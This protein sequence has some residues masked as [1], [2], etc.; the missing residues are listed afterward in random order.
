MTNLLD[1]VNPLQGTNSQYN[2]S[3][4]N[5]LPAIAMPWGM[6]LWSPQNHQ[7]NAWY[8]RYGHPMIDGIRLTHQPSPWMN[9]FAQVALMPQIGPLR[10]QTGA[11]A[12]S[13][14]VDRAT[15]KPNY[16]QI[17]LLRYQTRL[18]MVPTE[19][20][21]L[22]RI[23]Y[24][25]RTT[26]R[27]IIDAAGPASIEIQSVS[28]S[29]NAR[30]V[31]RTSAATDGALPGF[32]MHFV[33]ELDRPI[34]GHGH[35]PVAPRNNEKA[36]RALTYV[37]FDTADRPLIARIATSFIDVEQAQLNLTR[38]LGADSLEQLR[39]RTGET[40]NALLGRVTLGGA[41]DEQ[42]RTF[43]TCLYRALLFPTTGHEPDASG[44]Q[45]H[46]SF[47]DGKIH[48]GVQFTNN[49]FWDTYRT[50]YPLYSILY[51][52][53]LVQI[54][55][56]WLNAYRQSG[57]LPQWPSPGHRGCMI[58]S[59]I[60]PV[61]ADAIVKNVGLSDEEAALAFEAMRKHAFEPS[62]SASVG[63]DGIEAYLRYGFIP[64]GEA[65][66]ATS[67]T[68][69]Y[70][71]DDWCIA[72]VA[73]KIGR[74]EDA[75]EF[76]RRA[77]N[78]RNVFDPSI[79][80]ARP[81]KADGSWISPFDPIDWGGPFVEGSAWQCSWA[82]QHD[83][84]G[85]ANLLGGPEAF[86]A[87]LDQMLAMPPIFGAGHYSGEIHEMT[88]MAIEN[89]GQ[90]GHNNQPSHHSLFLFAAV[91][92]PW[93][94]QYWTRRVCTDLYNAGPD[95][96]C[97]DEDNGEMASWYI[98][99]SLGLC[100]LC[101][102]HPSYV[103]TSPLFPRATIHLPGGRTFTVEAQGNAPTHFY[104]RDLTL[105]GQRHTATWIA[106]ESITAGGALKMRMTADPD[107]RKVAPEDL[108]YSMSAKKGR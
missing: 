81:R 63:R 65:R 17:D 102:G 6:N 4:G 2:L 79:G 62:A 19:R 84:L 10:P 78:Y 66:H 49:G 88:E 36:P 45:R 97:G 64:D 54:I 42:L 105:N 87:K 85:M 72:Q 56:G 70:A 33:I 15:F 83:P 25:A 46:W 60:D 71:Y 20:C 91:G 47:Y 98:L 92:Q 38:E 94:T 27:F 14:R 3:H 18:E 90:Y 57:W 77:L 34:T 108:P 107:E 93:K 75:A 28:T 80:F 106:H 86:A 16:L 58:G 100:P 96:F 9:D 52:E 43:Y 41:T 31:G 50:V 24:P 1:Y 76:E 69:D 12:S 11:R 39:A 89:F 74:A 68:L 37:E 8:F 101:P 5:C 22:F 51:P 82:V 44:K 103:L 61:L 104:T 48:E 23:T 35:V 26:G 99:C 95:G 21:A 55:R 32:A 67:A 53:Q 29:G 73:A 59:H 40:W 13:Y 7:D 30:I